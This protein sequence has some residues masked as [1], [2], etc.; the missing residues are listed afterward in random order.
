MSSAITRRPT[1]TPA[2]GQFA[3]VLHGEAPVAL[4]RHVLGTAFET[5]H[6]ADM[7]RRLQAL[8]DMP[9]RTAVAASKYSDLLRESYSCYFSNGEPEADRATATESLR[10]ALGG[11]PAHRREEFVSLIGFAVHTEMKHFEDPEYLASADHRYELLVDAADY[12]GFDEDPATAT[13]DNRAAWALLADK[14]AATALAE[15]DSF[16]PMRQAA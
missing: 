9:V 4:G 13:E 1:G 2:G 15:A 8:P 16:L 6:G 14:A 5:A 10:Q 7:T 11:L 12:P 3:P